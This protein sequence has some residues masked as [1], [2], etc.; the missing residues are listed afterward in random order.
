MWT[1]FYLYLFLRFRRGF[2]YNRLLFYFDWGALA[3]HEARQLLLLAF[4]LLLLRLDD[5]RERLRLLLLIVSLFYL[6][7]LVFVQKVAREALE[8]VTFPFTEVVELDLVTYGQRELE[9]DMV[10]QV[11]R[12]IKVSFLLTLP[13]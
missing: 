10:A 8:L 4:P 1:D 7:S 9:H 5:N 2:N 6:L 13:L 12:I 11:F 3:S